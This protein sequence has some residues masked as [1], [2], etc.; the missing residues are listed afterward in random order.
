MATRNMQGC[1]EIFRIYNGPPSFELA[2]S[3]YDS[4]RH[5]DFSIVRGTEEDRKD[6]GNYGCQ[7]E[8]AT[9]MQ[10]GEWLLVG[11]MTIGA[12]GGD[13]TPARM[14]ANYNSNTRTGTLYCDVGNG[15][16]EKPT[17]V[18]VINIRLNGKSTIRLDNGGR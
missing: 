10:D 11:Q 4:T 1:L 5:L 14:F 15:K 8:S 16:K 3:V 18:I 12:I 13:K 17:G 2:L 6:L 7:I 9:R